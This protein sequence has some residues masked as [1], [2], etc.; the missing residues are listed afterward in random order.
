MPWRRNYINLLTPALFRP[1]PHSGEVDESSF[2]SSFGEEAYKG[3][4]EKIKEYIMAGDVFQVVLAQRMSIPF[5]GEPINIY[6]A[7][8]QLNPSPYMVFMDLEDFHIV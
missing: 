6:R 2:I 1:L 5:D 3:A 4:V 8:R 7:L